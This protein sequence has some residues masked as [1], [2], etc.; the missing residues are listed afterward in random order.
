MSSPP[1]QTLFRPT[2]GTHSPPSGDS[3]GEKSQPPPS[4]PLARHHIF[5]GQSRSHSQPAEVA[6][7]SSECSSSGWQV[8]KSGE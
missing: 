2:K 8:P 5:S 3:Y 7:P 4:R 1:P 6:P